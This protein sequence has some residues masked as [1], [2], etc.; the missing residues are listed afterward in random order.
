MAWGNLMNSLKKALVIVP[1]VAL[2]AA[3][4]Q[5]AEACGG[6]FVPPAENT[7]VTGHRMILS[8]SKTKTTLID[9]IEYSGDPQSFA[10]VL[11]IKGQAELATVPDVMFNQLG[12]D[13]TV[14]VI[15]PPVNCPDYGGCPG[16]GE[17]LSVASGTGGMG[18]DSDGGVTVISQEVVGPYETV[19]LAAT[20]PQALFN[21]LDGHGYQLPDDIA[22]IVASYIDADFNFLALRLV[23]GIGVSSM[24][25]IAVSL[26]GGSPTLPLRMVAAGTGVTTTVTLYVLSEGLME[27]TS[28]P[29]FTIPE[30][31]VVWRYATGDS[32]YTDLRKSAYD[33]SNGFGWLIEAGIPYYPSGFSSQ[34]HNVIDFLSPESAGY[35]DLTPAEAHAAADEDIALLFGGLDESSVR[36]TR[37]RAELSRD[38]LKTDLVLGARADQGAISNVIQTT[39][40][41]GTQPAC[42][43]PPDCGDDDVDWGDPWAGS[44]SDGSSG[45]TSSSSCSLSQ[46]T[47]SR[48]F[49]DLTGLAL[50]STFLLALVGFARRRRRVR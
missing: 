45:T 4:P 50:G 33:S 20:D 36:L 31:A 22:P 5:E 24:E 37:L 11:P 9:Q 42:P 43:P 23:P 32:N 2:T 40:F 30:E 39:L 47:A 27:A 29:T 38:S 41:T 12:F 25:P 16:V 14:S 49:G 46:R 34:I 8:V 13:S 3:T 21:W 17:S 15:P 26:P 35:P 7:L 19:Q 44:G 10:W 28:H 1:F 6:C 48:G 18:G